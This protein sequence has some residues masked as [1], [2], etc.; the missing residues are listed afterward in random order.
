[1]NGGGVLDASQLYKNTQRESGATEA[2]QIVAIRDA[3]SVTP[4]PVQTPSMPEISAYFR[5]DS[6]KSPTRRVGARFAFAN[7]LDERLGR[8]GRESTIQTCST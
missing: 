7:R 8:V 6:W 4:L 1:M 2:N 3:K 5:A